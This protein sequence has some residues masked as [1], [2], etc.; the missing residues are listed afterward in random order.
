MSD[1]VQSSPFHQPKLDY[2]SSRLIQTIL[3]TSR[4][5]IVTSSRPVYHAI[6]PASHSTWHISPLPVSLS[7]SILSH[8]HSLCPSLSLSSSP[9]P[10]RASTTRPTAPSCPPPVYP[11]RC[12]ASRCLHPRGACAATDPNATDTPV[13]NWRQQDCKPPA[14]ASWSRRRMCAGE[15]QPIS[16]KPTT[17][18][19]P[20]PSVITRYLPGPAPRIIVSRRA[21]TQVP[22]SKLNS[23]LPLIS[24]RVLLQHRALRGTEMCVSDRVGPR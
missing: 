10:P 24:R 6:A 16:S 8:S 22:V 19:A 13:P 23:S 18:T 1:P 15:E 7:R 20:A 11:P 12:P 4:P 3:Y 17:G 5:R 21:G 9:S 14:A 2:Q